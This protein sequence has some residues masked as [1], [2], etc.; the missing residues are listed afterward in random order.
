MRHRQV[1]G[2]RTP[3]LTHNAFRFRTAQATRMSIALHCCLELRSLHRLPGVVKTGEKRGG[4]QVYRYDPQVQ[5]RRK[6]QPAVWP[7]INKLLC[8]V[9]SLCPP[10]SLPS[11]VSAPHEHN[12]R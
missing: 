9:Y 7:W 3:L 4:R 1:S 2:A 5:N 11:C 10:A 6:G 12:S 8:T